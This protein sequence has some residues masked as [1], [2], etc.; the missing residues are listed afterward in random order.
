MK[1]YF[2][3]ETGTI[4]WLNGDMLMYTPMENTA[5]TLDTQIDGYVVDEHNT[6]LASSPIT[7]HY[8][9]VDTATPQRTLH[10]VWQDVRKALSNN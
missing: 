10:D 2:C 8:R 9:S 7:D 6:E 5:Y 1:L 4:Y 3:H